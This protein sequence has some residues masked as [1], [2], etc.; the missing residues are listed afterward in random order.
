MAAAVLDVTRVLHFPRTMR[1]AKDAP[2]LPRP[3]AWLLALLDGEVLPVAIGPVSA[4]R[5]TYAHRVLAPG[6]ME[7]QA[8]GDYLEVLRKGFVEPDRSLRRSQVQAMVRDAAASEGLVAEMSEALL[9]EVTDLCEWP[10]AFLG[11]F[12]PEYLDVPDPVLVATMVHHQRFFPLRTPEGRL[13]ARFCAVRNGGDEAVVRRGNETVLAARLADALFFYREDQKASFSAC[14]PELKGIAYAPRLGSLYDRTE[15][16]SRLAPALGR[17]AG[18]DELAAVLERAGELSLC[19]RLTALVREL[20]ELEGTMGGVYARIGGEED[21]VA[22]AIAARVRPR[23][24]DDELPPDDPG[25]LLALADR[26]DQLVGFLALGKAP[27]GSQ[28]PFG[29]RRAAIGALRL[30]ETLPDLGLT[31]ALAAAAEGYLDL[32]G[33][34]AAAAPD[35][36]RPFLAARLMARAQEAGHDARIVQAVLASGI[37]YPSEVMPRIAALEQAAQGETWT[38]LVQAARRAKNLAV[39]GSTEGCEDA[40]RDLLRDV[41][42]LEEEGGLLL[43]RRDYLGYLRRAAELYEP[44]DGFFAAVMVMA[45]DPEVRGRRQ[46]LL[47]R[48]HKA[49]SQVAEIAALS[50]AE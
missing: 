5:V 37:E 23:G 46:A 4:G 13:A 38:R 3:L 18:R 14:R 11:D 49:L 24:G 29:L 41:S 9:E 30:W 39:A 34:D 42:A 8:A 33:Q 1:W 31:T 25:R 15:R 19:D 27:T 7:V 45:E 40:E 6:P 16:L 20:P 12:A 43:A 17:A 36:V 21:A 26:L 35:A 44:L 2:R 28:D 48:A 50:A 47:H 10:Q 32:L 22:T